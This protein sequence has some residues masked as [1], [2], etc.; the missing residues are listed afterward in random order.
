MYKVYAD[1]K[2]T[3]WDFGSTDKNT[4]ILNQATPIDYLQNFGL[5]DIPIHYFIST[6]DH[7]CRPDDVMVQYLKLRELHPELAHL[8][9]FEG[10]SH[11]DFTYLNVNTMVTEVIKTLKSE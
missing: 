7:L 8:R 3:S 1:Q 10:Y 9:V 2:Y 4:E 11:I 5:I 6:G